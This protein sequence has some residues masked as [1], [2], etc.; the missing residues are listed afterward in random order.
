LIWLGVAAGAAAGS[1]AGW[2]GHYLFR[3]RRD[4]Q[5]VGAGPTATEMP[6]A[7]APPVTVSGRVARSAGS[8][9]ASSSTAA[10][11]GR[12]IVHLSSLGRLGNDE[13]A[14]PGFTQQ[15][16][17]SA[18]DL[19]QGTLAKVLARLAAANVIEVDRRHVQ[20]QPR[21]LKVYRLTR[22]GESVARDLR[23]PSERL[24]AEARDSRS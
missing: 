8:G 1:V 11:A 12:V 6:R 3:R 17:A 19:R 9:S 7:A 2:T 5:H 18:L 13:V 23:H 22:L 20:G 14:R 21:R 16:M 15:G 24:P 10:T 4:D